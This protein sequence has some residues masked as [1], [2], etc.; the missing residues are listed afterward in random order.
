MSQKQG[1]ERRQNRAMNDNFHA[2]IAKNR[3]NMPQK[4]MKNTEK[5][6]FNGIK[7]TSKC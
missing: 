6:P 5:V 1:M 7:Y 4:T 2:K 3:G